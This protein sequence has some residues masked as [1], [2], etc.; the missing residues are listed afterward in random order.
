[1]YNR[2]LITKQKIII[3]DGIV[4]GGKSLMC[5]LISSLPK[6]DQWMGNYWFDQIAALCDINEINL[7]TAS[8]IL[9]TNHNQIFYDSSMLRLSNF[10]KSD[11]T[12]VN[13]HPRYKIIKKR[14]QPNDQKIYSKF[15]DHIFSQYCTH[16]S[17]NFSEPF[18]KAFK[19]NLLF[20]QLLRSP[21]NIGMLKHLALW[22]KKWEKLKSRDGCIKFY[23][24][25]FKKNFPHYVADVS[26]E[27]LK[28]NK[29]EK[30]I[31]ILEQIYNKRKIN[32]SKKYEKKYGSK[33]IRVPY[34]NL[35]VNPTKYLNKI[36]K[37]LNVKIDKI[38]LKAMKR[39]NV[40]RKF[41]LNNHDEEGKKYMHNKID[42]QYFKRLTKLNDYY[43]KFILNK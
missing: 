10:R 32:L 28:A 35:I 5:N 7:N 6:V 43:K 37:V 27:Y 11:L 25:K 21:L 16:I 22:S 19:K 38:A 31:I 42:K 2:Q 39:N 17:A 29:F 18:F 34:E 15:K 40:P 26:N 1:M 12:A 23:N 4:G 24:K 14:L 36:S 8:Y 13:S 9:L 20:I 41:I 30:A 33:L 3:T